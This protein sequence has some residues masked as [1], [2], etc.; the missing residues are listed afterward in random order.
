M[1][2]DKNIEDIAKKIFKLIKKYCFSRGE[3]TKILDKASYAVSKNFTT[4]LD[5]IKSKK[6]NAVKE[7]NKD[8]NDAKS[9][10]LLFSNEMSE[11]LRDV[12]DIRTNFNL[13]HFL[14][15]IKYLFS[16]FDKVEIKGTE[17]MASTKEDVILQCGEQDININLGKFRICFDI[18]IYYETKE[19]NKAILAKAI[20][21]RL[22]YSR[23]YTHPHV[24]CNGAICLGDGYS[25]IQ[26]AIKEYRISD[27]FQIVQSILKTYG[28]DPMVYLDDFRKGDDDE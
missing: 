25:L 22:D 15:E 9:L 7:L 3:L 20:T 5:K 17:I 10:F 6:S 2:K 4:T 14:A 16:I 21:P 26:S 28:E 27:I 8:I 13:D 1:T 11:Y 24:N 23:N 19:L 18:E 12:E